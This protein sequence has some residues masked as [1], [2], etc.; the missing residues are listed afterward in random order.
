MKRVPLVTVGCS[1][2]T[3]YVLAKIHTG[4]RKGKRDC[5]YPDSSASTKSTRTHLRLKGVEADSESASSGDDSIA[6]DKETLEPIQDAEETHEADESAPP[7]ATTESGNLPTAA[8][9]TNVKSESAESSAAAQRPPRPQ[10][11]RTASKHASKPS[12]SQNPRW[13][14]L[15]RDVKAYLKYHRDHMSYHHYAFKYDGGDFLKTTFIEIAL[16]DQSQALL[17]AIVAFAAYHYAL[18]LEDSRISAFLTYYNQSIMMLQQSLKN[19]RPSVTTL[20]TILQLATIEV[21]P[22]YYSCEPS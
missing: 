1:S 13:S 3:F 22:P 2:P 16:N 11:G 6:D 14:A 10:A 21:R 4:C 9:S 12:I 5:S 20:L 8:S 7:S 19:K 15:P 17:Y 18:A